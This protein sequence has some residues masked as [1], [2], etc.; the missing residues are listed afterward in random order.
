M[1][2]IPKLKYSIPWQDPS[3]RGWYSP[4][5]STLLWKAGPLPGRDMPPEYIEA[6]CYHTDDDTYEWNENPYPISKYSVKP[7]DEYDIRPDERAEKAMIKRMELDSEARRERTEKRSH[8][9]E[10]GRIQ[11]ASRVLDRE[12]TLTDKK[13]ADWLRKHKKPLTKSQ[14]DW[15]L[16]NAKRKHEENLDQ[17]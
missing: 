6:W 7:K 14:R 4:N 1:K 2:P 11:A 8:T 16:K 17:D 5:G 13:E 3:Y 12:K 9:N 10:E 15:A